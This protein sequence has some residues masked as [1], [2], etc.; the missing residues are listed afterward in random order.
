MN[1]YLAFI[2]YIGKSVDDKFIYRFDFTNDS[3]S[4]WGDYFNIAPAVI[5]PDLQPEENT[6]IKTARVVFDKEI[7]LAKK[8]GCF[9]MQDCFDG[10]I[11]LGFSEL[12]EEETIYY[13][14]EP[15]FFDFGESFEVTEDKIKTCGYEFYDIIEKEIGDESIISD[16]IENIKEETSN[17]DEE[18][19]EI[20]I[21]KIKEEYNFEN[22]RQTLY[23]NN[24]QFVDYVKKNGEYTFRGHIIDIYSYGEVYPIRLSFF[25][26]T[27]EKITTFNEDTQKEIQTIEEI[28]IF[29]NGKNTK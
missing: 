19:Y 21:F 13:K 28:T 15:L 22:I 25:G 3:D 27:L 11:S 23:S 2:D 29:G 26:N 16:L 7:N 6:I 8:N 24:Y 18:N 1:C 12:S 10:I 14:D 9:S 4:V 5:V 17:K 20:L